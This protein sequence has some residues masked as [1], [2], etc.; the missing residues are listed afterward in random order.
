MSL[1]NTRTLQ[2]KRN[3]GSW[4]DGYWTESETSTFNILGTWQPIT[5]KKLEVYQNGD[6]SLDVFTGFTSTEIFMDDQIN[7]TVSDII[8][9]DSN[10]YEIIKID[11][12]QNNIINNYEFVA[13]RIL[14]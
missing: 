14:E 3:T 10:D 13:T 6:R 2:V 4:V 1:F 5:G 9:V 12:W 8:T 11:K 7:N